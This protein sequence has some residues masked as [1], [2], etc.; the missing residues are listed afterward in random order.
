MSN[1][2]ATGTQK[3][4]NI[5]QKFLESFNYIPVQ[6]TIIVKAANYMPNGVVRFGL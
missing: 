1:S 3:N 6:P 5:K 2:E 4:I